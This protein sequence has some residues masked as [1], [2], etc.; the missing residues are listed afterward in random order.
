MKEIGNFFIYADNK[1]QRSPDGTMQFEVCTISNIIL[2]AIGFWQYGY[3]VATGQITMTEQ[4]NGTHIN[5]YL[6]TPLTVFLF[7]LIAELTVFIAIGAVLVAE[8]Q[9]PGD[10][11]WSRV[12]TPL[13]G[14]YGLVLWVQLFYGR[15]LLRKAINE[16]FS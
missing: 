9:Y 10:F 14:A 11:R 6:Q 2:V 3:S 7:T 12:V 15:W 5:G 13:A 4:G 1:M 8:T 16:A